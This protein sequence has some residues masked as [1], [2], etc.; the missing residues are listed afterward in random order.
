MAAHD[1]AVRRQTTVC[2]SSSALKLIARARQDL[3]PVGRKL[4]LKAYFDVVILLGFNGAKDNDTPGHG[5]S[6]VKLVIRTDASIEIGSG[7]LMRCL[8]IANDMQSKGASI[9][10]VSRQLPGEMSSLV[11]QMGH[12][13]SM[14]A[15]PPD[16]CPVRPNDP[17]HGHWLGVPWEVDLQETQRAMDAEKADWLIVDHYG[18]DFRWERAMRSHASH[19]LVFD[20]LADR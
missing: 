1:T 11:R 13:V 2:Q 15:A 20:D 7:H 3:A 12:E 5:R 4:R 6:S 8:S 18:L 14:L 9:R 17:K 16:T 10:F 19:I